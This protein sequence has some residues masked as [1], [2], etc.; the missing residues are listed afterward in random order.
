MEDLI[1]DF[2]F[3]LEKFVQDSLQALG[4]NFEDWMASKL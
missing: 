1:I 3:P 2:W 4:Q